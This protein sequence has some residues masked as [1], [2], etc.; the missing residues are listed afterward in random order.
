MGGND[1]GGTG[2][3]VDG[4]RGGHLTFA[5]IAR[6]TY[7]GLRA[8]ARYIS[9]TVWPA[10]VCWEA[11]YIV[12]VLWPA[13]PD[14][15]IF[16]DLPVILLFIMAESAWYQIC[17]WGPGQA[18]TRPFGW[19]RPE[20]A[21]LIYSVPGAIALG[22]LY[23]VVW[24]LFPALDAPS[25]LLPGVPETVASYVATAAVY[26]VLTPLF[27]LVPARVIRASARTRTFFRDWGNVSVALQ[28]WA[29]VLVLPYP[30]WAALSAFD[31]HVIAETDGRLDTALTIGTGF[32]Y[33]AVDLGTY[34]VG[35]TATAAMARQLG[36]WQRHAWVRSDA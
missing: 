27:L 22:V 21:C 14:W 7:D 3:T 6:D 19:R 29:A 11:L 20:T 23:A 28:V 15:F 30:L 35:L 10:L 34:Y 12:E 24:G 5:V 4:P 16:L 32:V 18:R 8:N 17:L 36:G 1:I 31:Y 25:A 26:T 33:T 9:R 2:A 13:V